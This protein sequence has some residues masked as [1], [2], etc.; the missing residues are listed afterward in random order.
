MKIAKHETGAQ[1][2]KK[3][4]SQKK[5]SSFLP[6]HF[7]ALKPFFSDSPSRSEYENVILNF[8]ISLLEFEKKLV[9][10]RIE[11]LVTSLKNASSIFL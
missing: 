3:S 9:L 8:C 6:C 10:E 11:K 7:E 5:N 4:S 1:N 2:R